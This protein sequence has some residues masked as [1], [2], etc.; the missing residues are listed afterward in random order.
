MLIGLGVL[1]PNGQQESSEI[2]SADTMVEAMR[3]S[4][5]AKDFTREQYDHLAQYRDE[6]KKRGFFRMDEGQ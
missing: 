1:D 6:L 3:N 5:Y 2:A 4:K